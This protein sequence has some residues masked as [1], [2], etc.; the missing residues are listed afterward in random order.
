MQQGREVFFSRDRV[1]NLPKFDAQ[2]LAPSLS[3][4]LV[5]PQALS[6]VVA[7]EPGTLGT[8]AIEVIQALGV[9]IERMR[10][11]VVDR[12][13][14]LFHRLVPMLVDCLGQLLRHS[15]LGWWREHVPDLQGLLDV[16]EPPFDR[17]V[18]VIWIV[19]ILRIWKRFFGD[20]F[21]DLCRRAR[22]QVEAE[23]LNKDPSDLTADAGDNLCAH[24]RLH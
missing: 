21:G 10:E 2:F 12:T 13:L 24:G 17:L 18:E 7:G 19:K 15:Q 6:I 3:S 5:K 9:I 14:Q 11:D 23:G 4:C 1:E 8:W 22:V 16:N 20:F